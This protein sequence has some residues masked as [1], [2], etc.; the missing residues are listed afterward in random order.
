MC[1]R[2][3]FAIRNE[4][5]AHDVHGM[6]DEHSQEVRQGARISK[7]QHSSSKCTGCDSQCCFHDLPRACDDSLPASSDTCGSSVRVTSLTFCPLPCTRIILY[8]PH[9]M[10]QHGP[11][12]PSCVDTCDQVVPLGWCVRNVLP[13][14]RRRTVFLQT[15]YRCLWLKKATNTCRRHPKQR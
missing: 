14:Q 10:Q 3:A 8:R 1:G 7:R 5:F 6:V 15:P 13:P 11:H 4:L 9:G 12:S 2:Q